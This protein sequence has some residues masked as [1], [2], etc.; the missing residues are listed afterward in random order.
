M[1]YRNNVIPRICLLTEVFSPIVGGSITHARL[2]SEKL[3]ENGIDL[4]VITRQVNSDLREY[5]VVGQIPVHR[6]KPTGFKRF[7]K[8][9]MILPV[10]WQL[11][12]KRREY[13]IL[14]VCGIRI[15][16][17][18]AVCI[19]ILLRKKC[20]L[21][22][23]ACG[24][25]SGD[26]IKQGI[27]ENKLLLKS[28][29]IIVAFLNQIL[30]KSDCFVSITQVIEN[31]LLHC[32]V[33]PRKIKYI[34]NGIDTNR[35]SSV[36]E[37][38]KSMLQR[39]F[40]IPQNRLVFSYSGRL[41]KG[42]GL[43][44]LLRVWKRLVEEEKGLHLVLIGP[45]GNQFLSCENELRQ[46]ID[47]HKL[48]ESVTFTGSVVNVYEY[49]QCSD[50]FILLSESEALPISLLEGLSCELPCIAT[51]VGG[52]PDL[53][54]NGK[55]G[56]LVDVGDEEG[57]YNAVVELIKNMGHAKKMGKEGRKMVIERFSINSVSNE[58]ITLFTSLLNAREEGNRISI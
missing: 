43:E 47:K 46:F 32:N 29:E 28:I 7:G 45:G 14:Y 4:F 52:I 49:L 8:Y 33:D 6:V 5:E 39:K 58:Y 48:G 31:E 51:K 20:I 26:F 37:N 24:E 11:F 55:N 40:K 17:Y 38:I 16:G 30:K 3:I 2:L 53:I 57:I 34:P 21:R 1:N 19:S 42:K 36:G 56:K 54:Q 35:F 12:K 10:F 50:C 41:S 13:N 27:G 15:L 23:E 22:P 9:L 44:L 18:V 25:M